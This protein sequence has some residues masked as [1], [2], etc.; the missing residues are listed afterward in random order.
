[1]TMPRKYTLEFTPA[2]FVAVY[3]ALAIAVDVP[4]DEL[5][6]TFG[7]GNSVNAALRARAKLDA[8]YE[9]TYTGPLYTAAESLGRVAKR[10]ALPD[11]Q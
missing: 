2:E 11:P 1:M 8:A 10:A 7:G 6:D 4:D 9:E 3:R 5:R